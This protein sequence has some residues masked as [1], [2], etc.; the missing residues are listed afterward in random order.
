MSYTDFWWLSSSHRTEHLYVNVGHHRPISDNEDPRSIRRDTNT[1]PINQL[2]AWRER[3]QNTNVYRGLQITTDP[4]DSDG[5]MGPFIVDIDNGNEDIE[6]AL[7][8]TKKTLALLQDSFDISIENVRL[9]FTGHKGFNLEVHPRA[10]S[11]FGSI[12]EQI[13]KSA[14]ILYQIIKSLRIG[15]S[16]Q[17][18]NQV[19]DRGTVIDQIYGSRYSGYRLKHPDLRLHS[20]INKWIMADGKAMTRMKIEIILADLNQ[21]DAREIV[22]RSEKLAS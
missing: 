8:V 14:D 17:T 12:N 21:L 9:F 7:A 19:S 18:V 1:C 4:P 2:N 10:F 3:F 20:S 6:D 15:D 13:R 5:L 22:D 16:W 11:L